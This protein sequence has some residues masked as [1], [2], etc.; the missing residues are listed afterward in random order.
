MAVL[1]G[2]AGGSFPWWRRSLPSSGKGQSLPHSAPQEKSTADLFSYLVICQALSG[3]LAGLVV[4]HADGRVCALCGILLNMC[5]RVLNAAASPSFRAYDAAVVLDG[6]A[7]NLVAFPALA[8]ADLFPSHPNCSYAFVLTAEFLGATVTPAMWKYYL[9]HPN[10]SI[11]RL[12]VGYTLTVAL[13]L[14]LIFLL[15]VP[16]KGTKLGRHMRGATALMNVT[17]NE[18]DV[19]IEGSMVKSTSSLVKAGEAG[20]NSW[21]SKL[22]VFL[23]Q[24]A[25]IQFLLFG[26][27]YCIFMFQV[28]GIRS[29]DLY[30]FR[31]TLTILRSFET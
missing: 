1:V 6:L 3:L 11:V 24:L 31:S 4:D 29:P 15:V 2:R 30:F 13:P 5:A 17:T 18:A 20:E 25:S 27:V 16:P 8:L 14:G 7:C 26:I 10:V 12:W 19:L 21:R 28:R 9:G 22:L 23:R